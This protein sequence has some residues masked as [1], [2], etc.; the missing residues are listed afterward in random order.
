MTDTAELKACPFCGA[1]SNLETG[2]AVAWLEVEPGATLEQAVGEYGALSYSIQFHVGRAK[3][4]K[5][6]DA[7]GLFPLYP[8]RAQGNGNQLQSDEN[9]R[10]RSALRQLVHIVDQAGVYHLSD[11]VQSGSITQSEWYVD[12]SDAMDEARLA[13]GGAP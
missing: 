11:G 10:L 6:Q 2:K 7:N 4:T 3:P 8:G 9:E 12:M 13:I 5:R 1:V